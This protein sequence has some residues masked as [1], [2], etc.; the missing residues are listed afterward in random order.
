MIIAEMKDEINKLKR[1]HNDKEIKLNKEYW[2]SE[3]SYDPL[4][5]GYDVYKATITKVE[6]VNGYKVYSTNKNKRYYF[7]W[8]IHNSRFEADKISDLKNS[9][10]YD[11]CEYEEKLINEI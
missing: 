7:A 6:D 9:Y 8:D 11:Y 1:K 2:V 5:E 4:Y 10:L 3:W